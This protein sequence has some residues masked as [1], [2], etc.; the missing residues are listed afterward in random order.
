MT[1]CENLY[2]INSNA[3]KMILSKYNTYKEQKTMT[4]KLKWPSNLWEAVKIIKESWDWES[5]IAEV[6]RIKL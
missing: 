1:V 4:N 2:F 6:L 3:V 5:N